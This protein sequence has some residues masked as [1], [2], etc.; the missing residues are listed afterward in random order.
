MMQSCW[1]ISYCCFEELVG[2]VLM[3][4]F[5]KKDVR[6]KSVYNRKVEITDNVNDKNKEKIMVDFVE[7]SKNRYTTKVY[8]PS[9]KIPE[10]MID[11]LCMV[12]RNSPSSVNSQPWHFFLAATDAAKEKIAPAIMDFNK[13]RVLDAS[14]VVIFCAKTELNDE[15]LNQ[16]LA[17]E[18]K[19]GRFSIEKH[20]LEQDAGRRAFVNL[21][22]RTQESLLAWE[23]KQIYLAMG[24]LLYAAA[25]MGIDST[26][27]EGFTTAVMDEIL[28]LKAKGLTSV[29]VVSLGYRAKDDFNVLRP[30]SRLMKEDLFTFL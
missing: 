14:H 22:S 5:G 27:I 11:D 26:P 21:N 13:P 4:L 30:K 18:E 16:L 29:V 1:L 9:K 12:L 25:S 3:R 6:K 15:H 19:D 8:D 17:Q 10:A 20:K 28:G 23:G 24:S 2:F 7:L